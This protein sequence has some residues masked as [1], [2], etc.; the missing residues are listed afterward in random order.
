HTTGP[1]WGS[2]AY[3]APTL[4][5]PLAEVASRMPSRAIGPQWFSVDRKART[6]AFEMP[7]PSLMRP[8][9]PLRVPVKLSGLSAG[10]EARVV[11]AAV[12]VGILNLTNYKPPAPDDYYLGQRRLTA[13]LRD[14]YGQLLDGMQGTRGT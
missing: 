5:R 4:R 2:R 3:V 11:V 6:L 7:L 13:E 12:D 10:E 1:D 8:T 14:L 9:G